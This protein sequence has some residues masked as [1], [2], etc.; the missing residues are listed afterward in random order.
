MSFFIYSSVIGSQAREPVHQRVH[1][2]LCTAVDDSVEMSVPGDS[3]NY[4]G[5]QGGSVQSKAAQYIAI[6]T[7]II[8]FT[9]LKS[10]GLQ[11]HTSLSVC[12]SVCR[13]RPLLF[14]LD[15]VQ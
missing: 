14:H 15:Y 9:K 10:P 2:R 8:Y 13:S 7:S 11:T 12:L 3:T 4:R 1:K 5:E 6:F